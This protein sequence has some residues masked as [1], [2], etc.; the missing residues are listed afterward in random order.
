MGKSAA[1]RKGHVLVVDDDREIRDLLG[2]FL[3]NHGY[4]VTVTRDGKEM[5]RALDSW[6]I[7]LDCSRSH[8]AG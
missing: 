1:D 6:R 7:D 2:R 8:A 4:R 5:W 3:R